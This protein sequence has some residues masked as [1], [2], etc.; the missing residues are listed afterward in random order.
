MRWL[1]GILVIIGIS[2]AGY[3]YWNRRQSIEIQL[4][5]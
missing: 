5:A 2:V 3:A 1:I 4:G